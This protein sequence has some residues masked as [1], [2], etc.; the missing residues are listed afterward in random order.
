MSDRGAASSVR[1]DFLLSYAAEDRPWAEWLAWQLEAAGYRVLIEAWDLVPGSNRSAHV[2]R[3]ALEAERTIAILSAAYL[4]SC[5]EQPEWQ[6]ALEADPAGFKRKLLPVRIEDCERPGVLGPIAAID[7]FGL[8]AGVARK[9]FLHSIQAAIKGRDKPDAEPAFPSARTITEPAFPEPAGDKPAPGEPSRPASP[10]T[11]PG[12]LVRWVGTQPLAHR[13]S[14]GVSATQRPSRD[15]T[16]EPT[17]PDVR[18]A[19]L[20]HP[21]GHVSRRINDP[22]RKDGPTEAADSGAA[23]RSRSSGGIEPASL[24]VAPTAQIRADGGAWSRVPVDGVRYLAGVSGAA[25]RAALSPLPDG[26]PAVVIYRPSAE[27]SVALQASLVAELDAVARRLFPSWLPGAELIDTPGGAGV[28]A[29]RKLAARMAAGSTMFA[30]Y[31]ADLAERSLTDELTNARFS[32]ETQAATLTQVIAGS[33]GR[34]RLILLV[35]LPRSDDVRRERALLNTLEWFAYQGRAGAWLTGGPLLY[36]DRIPTVAVP[37]PVAVQPPRPTAVAS[38]LPT[39][40]GRARGT[41][42]GG[43]D[44]D[45]ARVPAAEHPCSVDPASLADP[46][47]PPHPPPDSQL[48]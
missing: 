3:G 20:R 1:W 36:T 28:A 44:G 9:N 10:P 27:R 29:V 32:L 30:R 25:V 15:R 45:S 18:E 2:Q 37:V 16:D 26:A 12:D 23:E 33:F 38:C 47:H 11:D 39:E 7:L 6:A 41:G 35:D 43:P 19:A 17:G 24:T 13:P 48:P 21:R 8:A 42:T 46:P 14:G 5:Y 34:R 4:N 31:L 22:R 40:T